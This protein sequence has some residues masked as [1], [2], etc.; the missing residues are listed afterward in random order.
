MGY[1]S[2]VSMNLVS[3]KKNLLIFCSNKK[4]F[5][6]S[7][8]SSEVIFDSD[9][10][11]SLLV[12]SCFSRIEQRQKENEKEYYTQMVY[13]NT[14][15][16]PPCLFFYFHFL[17]LNMSSLE[18]WL[19]SLIRPNFILHLQLILLKLLIDTRS[20]FEYCFRIL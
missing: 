11:V 20:S 1:F 12:I 18:N 19:S 14:K 4:R 13:V 15:M 7:L 6:L 5:G 3:T 10:N 16:N 9:V 2:T 17:D 8:I